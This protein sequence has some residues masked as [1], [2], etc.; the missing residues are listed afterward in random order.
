MSVAPFNRDHFEGC[1][2]RASSLRAESLPESER[3]TPIER[4]VDMA[5]RIDN[6]RLYSVQSRTG[7]LPSLD[8][9]DEQFNALFGGCRG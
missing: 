8:S 7:V 9:V 1:I 4:A 6:H 5:K 3:P 2:A